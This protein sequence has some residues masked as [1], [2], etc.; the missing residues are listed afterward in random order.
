MKSIKMIKK[1]PHIHCARGPK[2][3]EKCKEWAQKGNDFALIEVFL[4]GGKV[5]RP[6]TEIYVGC[7]RIFGEY[8]VLRRFDS[9]EEAKQYAID[10][11]V[12]IV[13]D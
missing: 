1:M 12:E 13:F 8:D 2:G 3:C 4:E 9:D 6:M 10:H 11:G 7:Q 5:A